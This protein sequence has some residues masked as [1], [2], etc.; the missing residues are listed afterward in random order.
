MSRRSG[1][2]PALKTYRYRSRLAAGA[3]GH[4]GIRPGIDFDGVYRDV[5]RSF[6][7]AALAAKQPPYPAIFRQAGP[8]FCRLPTVRYLLGFS[9]PEVVAKTRE[10]SEV[11][12]DGSLA[13]V[14]LPLAGG[15]IFLYASANPSRKAGCLLLFPECASLSFPQRPSA[16]SGDLNQPLTDYAYYYN[17]A[18]PT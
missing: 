15:S 1:G 9:L 12:R 13:I 8:C 7:Q 6:R 4:P 11:N 2:S 18:L 5:H 17:G 10:P 16:Q 14:W 3:P